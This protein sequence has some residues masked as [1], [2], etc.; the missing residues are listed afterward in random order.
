MILISAGK[1]TRIR[2]PP[3][4]ACLAGF[5]NPSREPSWEHHWRRTRVARKAT[6]L[7]P[8][9]NVATALTDLQSGELVNASLSDVS[10]D[11][12]LREEIAFGHKYAL[13][14]I[15]KGETVVK[16]GMPI[17]K[18]LGDISPGE[19]VHVH[20]CRSDRFGFHRKEYGLKA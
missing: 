14:A 17:G 8:E 11:T 16:H 18:A 4:R 13:R 15:T 9:D 10:V 6:L 20:N 7:H 5:A 19:W 3:C 1:T 2:H 12:R